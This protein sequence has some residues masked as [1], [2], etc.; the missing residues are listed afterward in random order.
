MQNKLFKKF[1]EFGIGSILTLLIGFI[2]SPIITRLIS[3]NENGKFSMFTTVGN[4]IL[5]ISFLGL[6]QSYVRFFYDENEENR[7]KLI[8]SCMV[9]PIIVSIAIIGV[10]LI[11]Y[12]NISYFIIG[13]QSFLLIVILGIFLILSIVLRFATLQIRMQQKA[14]T[15][16]LVNIIQKLFNLG[17]VILLFYIFNN[18]YYT[19]VIASVISIFVACITA[20]I[21]EKKV[22]FETAKNVQIKTTKKDLLRYGIPLIFSMAITWVFQSTDRIVIKYFSGYSDLGLYNGAMTIIALLTA[23][24]GTFTTFWT[25]VAFEKYSK[26]PNDKEFFKNINEIVCVVMLFIG[27]GLICSKDIIIYL[28]GYKYRDSMY[29]FPYLVF[30]PIMY[31][32][33]ETT[34]IGINFEKNPK[35]QIKVA[36]VSAIFN[37]IG[38]L[39]LVPRFG[40]VGAAISTG[41]SYVVFW[42]MRTYFSQKHYKVNFEIKKFLLAIMLL[43]I[44]ATYS[45]FNKF[46]LVIFILM[47]FITIVYLILYAN[48]IKKIINYILKKEIK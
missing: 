28:L 6:D 32:I 45:S 31:T 12:K 4:L 48:T 13:E 14:K 18:S 42:A 21:V 30:M 36:I 40:A 33:S 25:P 46:N 41:L 7:G 5:M 10:L 29:I 22:W 15:Y 34:V 23:V 8:K 9:I 35:D 17:S 20:I 1:M 11:F 3:P 16:S 19:L 38:N 26:N 39:I 27:L 47:I 24:Q 37:V 2:S 43:Y 44:I